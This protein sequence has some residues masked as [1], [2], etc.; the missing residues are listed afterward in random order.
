MQAE[1]AEFAGL[2]RKIP[3]LFERKGYQ[4]SVPI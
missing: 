3:L 4:H 1:A 2:G